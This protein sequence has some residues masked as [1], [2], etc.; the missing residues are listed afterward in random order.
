MDAGEHARGIK[1]GFWNVRYLLNFGTKIF[2]LVIFS[3]PNPIFRQVG[4]TSQNPP[5]RKTQSQ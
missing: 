5:S 1:K 3:Q 4:K 2:L